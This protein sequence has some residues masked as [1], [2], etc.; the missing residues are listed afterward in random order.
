MNKKK[1]MDKYAKRRLVLKIILVVLIIF[2]IN[3]VF[4]KTK[5]LK[6][7]ETLF[8]VGSEIQKLEN[9]VIVDSLKNVYVSFDDVKKLYDE[10]IYYDEVNQELITTYN[11]HIAILKLNQ[12]EIMINDAQSKINGTLQYMENKLYLPFSDM[13]IVYDFEYNY[14][15]TTN[16]VIIDSISKEKIVAKILKKCNLKNKDKLFSKKIET[17]NVNEEVTVLEQG[18]RYSKI[19]TETGLIGYIKTSKIGE[20]KTIRKNM[21][22]SKFKDVKIL[23]NYSEISENYTDIEIEPNKYNVVV[24]NIFSIAENKNIELKVTPTSEKYKNYIS[25]LDK[26]NID[27]WATITND[28][29][30]SKI[31]LTFSERKEV[32]K[33]IYTK[34]I[35]NNYKV[36]NIDFEKINDINSFYRFLIEL[37]PLLREAGIKTVVTYNEVMNEEK[38]LKIVDYLVKDE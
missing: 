21:K 27:L 15:D 36:L 30:V 9:S 1:K 34:L 6:N 4:F 31:L 35:E 33:K 25:L 18:S 12:K 3:N 7:E 13:E 10:N 11:K 20:L 5:K 22:V 17:L 28:I 24:P 19:R 16:T 37:T 23:S 8:V 38:V 14:S 2:I 32:I 26:N 29:E